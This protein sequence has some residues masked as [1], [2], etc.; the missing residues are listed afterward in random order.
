MV[1]A[2]AIGLSMPAAADEIEDTIAAALEAYRAG[3]VKLAK[4]EIDFVQQLLAV[5]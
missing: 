5:F 3:D 2:V 1:A 4:E